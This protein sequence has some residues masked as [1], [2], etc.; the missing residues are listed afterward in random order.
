MKYQRFIYNHIPKCGGSSF[1][2]MLHNACT[3]NNGNFFFRKP[4]YISTVTHNN[5]SIDEIDQDTVKKIIHPNTC[6]FID[7]SKYNTIEKIFNI[8]ENICYR[9]TCVR[10]PISRILSHNDFF[11]KIPV[12]SLLNDESELDRLIKVCGK[13]MMW[14]AT[15]HSNDTDT[16]RYN[17]AKTIYKTKYKFIFCLENID[18][19]IN[20]F[21]QINPFGLKLNKLYRN[22]NQNKQSYSEELIDKIK[23]KIPEEIE[24]YNS[25]LE[26]KNNYVKT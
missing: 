20:H 19:D 12:E 23:S 11:V 1:R 14:Y 24:L 10:E 21:N 8:P 17:L 26:M 13:L 4:I 3:T 22:I 9:S 18:N 16:N 15:P 6:L 25:I 2:D 7:H 5:I